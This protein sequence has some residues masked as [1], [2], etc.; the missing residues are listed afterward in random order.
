QRNVLV[1][2]IEPGSP[3]DKAGLK[4][5]DRLLSIAA[6]NAAP[7]G[8]DSANKLPQI[9]KTYAGQTVSVV[10]LRDGQQKT[11]TVQLRDGEEGRKNGYLGVS[12]AE[13]SLTR[14]T[15]SAPVQAAGLI[16]QFTVITF[17]GI[18]TAL[19]ALVQGDTAK[20]SEQVSGP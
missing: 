10:Y 1:G 16:G 6:S 2:Y 7:R 18:G 14:A 12:P 19:G 13:F 5:H 9:T 11:A 4:S 20:A 15:W 3:A 17:Q 8:V